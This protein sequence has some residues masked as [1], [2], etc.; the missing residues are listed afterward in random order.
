MF[1]ESS[2]VIVC[3]CV[4][5]FGVFILVKIEK[6]FFIGKEWVEREGGIIEEEVE[7]VWGD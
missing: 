5:L 6:G 4:R 2:V 7:G 3:M 1:N